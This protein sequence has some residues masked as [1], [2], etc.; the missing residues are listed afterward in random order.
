MPPASSTSSSRSRA[1]TTRDDYADQ[2]MVL[3]E[4]LRDPVLRARGEAWVATLA[5]AVDE[6]LGRR[7]GRDPGLGELVVAQWQGTLIVW[8]FTRSGPLPTVVRR[9]LEAFLDRWW[10]DRRHPPV[11]RSEPVSRSSQ[12]RFVSCHGPEWFIVLAVVLVIF[13]GSQLPKLARN[14]G[15]P[16]SSRT[17]SRGRDEA[18]LTPSDRWAA[19]EAAQAEAVGDHEQAEQAMA[20]PASIGLRRPA[21]ASGMAATL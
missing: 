2:L 12:R 14:L 7:P 8:S 18:E 10:S 4:D 1:A 6:R 11:H 13:G 16:R 19:A 15:R 17:A 5:G 21:A 9:S 20:G 3:R